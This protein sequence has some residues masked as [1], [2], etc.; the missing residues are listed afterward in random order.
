MKHVIGAL[1]CA[2]ILAT[3][4]ALGQHHSAP[5][6]PGTEQFIHNLV[7]DLN[8]DGFEV[9]RGYP[10]LWTM[11]DCKYTYGV[12]FNCYAN[13][14]ASP[15]VVV[16]VRPWPDEFVD[17]AS[18]NVYGKTQPGYSSTFRLD[19]REAIVIF[20]T[21]PPPARYMGLQSYVFSHDWVIPQGD[22]DYPW[23]Y[24]WVTDAQQGGRDLFVD[25][26][27]VK[28]LF[29]TLP[30]H[31][32][33]VQSFSSVGNSI[34]NVVMDHGATGAS[35]GRIRY[36]VITPDQA[37]EQTVRL[38]LGRLGVSDTDVFT[39]TIAQR[40]HRAGATGGELGPIGLGEHALDFMTG[41]RYAMPENEQAA[42]A[43]RAQLPLTVLRVRE[44]ASST[45]PAVPYQ[46][47]V[48]DARE[49]VD[50]SF[51]K[52][53]LGALV[54]AVKGRVLA[55]PW[56]LRFLDAPTMGQQP[57]MGNVETWLGHFGP[58]CRSI[59]EN[60]LG[61]GQDAS[62]FFMPP[63][64]L[65][66]GQVYAVIGTLGTR[67]GNATYNGLSINDASRLKGVGNVPDLDPRSPDTD[68]EGSASGYEA[69]VANHGM[70]FVHFFTRDC[71]AIRGL[72]DG[73]C[74][75]ITESM[76]PPITDVGTP[77]D[78]NVRGFFTAGLRSYVK[79]G[80]A[81]GPTTTFTRDSVTRKLVYVSGQLP[82]VVLAFIPSAR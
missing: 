78:P 68:L 50:E 36:F 42:V 34:N 48:A 8:A 19:P 28:Y 75:T 22:A 77:G 55:G 23:G 60:C 21:M 32:K 51:L 13:N 71:D 64:P 81:R 67:T 18:V 46:E 35:F 69:A 11:E 40:F 27:M 63:Q 43:W 74:S 4:P 7:R 1:S 62:Y 25:S 52:A 72:T 56:N 47:L 24:P 15:Y 38:A 10:H 5:V 58:R 31:E 9:T 76:V 80:T 53:D 37:M 65:D 66:S 61:D 29:S 14:P 59:G 33:R 82:P 41:L 57:F 17:P 54:A 70:F 2:L 49:A 16:A 79:P 6:Q 12:A 26:P 20:G 73:A 44:P 39:E 30:R 3:W 45:R